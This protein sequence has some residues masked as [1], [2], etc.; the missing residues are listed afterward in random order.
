MLRPVR[1]VRPLRDVSHD[2]ARALALWYVRVEPFDI[3]LAGVL[4]HPI[5]IVMLFQFETVQPCDGGLVE[6]ACGKPEPRMVTVR[7]CGLQIVDGQ[8][9][10]VRYRANLMLRL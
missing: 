10:R 3:I 7:L 2:Q 4:I 1:R 5:R 6:V 9:R 8:R